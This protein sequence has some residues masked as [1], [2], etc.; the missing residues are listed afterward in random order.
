MFFY[1]VLGPCFVAVSF[2]FADHPIASWL[3]FILG[4]IASVLAI[5]FFILDVEVRSVP[6]KG[7]STDEKGRP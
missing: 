3:L 7:D 4:I 6:R 5:L 2:L 1:L